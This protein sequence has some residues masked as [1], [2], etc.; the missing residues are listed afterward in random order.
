MRRNYF[1]FFHKFCDNVSNNGVFTARIAGEMLKD[2]M[3]VSYIN[4]GI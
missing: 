3:P 4:S 2:L 1:L